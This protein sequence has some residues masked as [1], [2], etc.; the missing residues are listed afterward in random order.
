MMVMMVVMVASYECSM[1]YAMSAYCC[2]HDCILLQIIE[3]V[4]MCD[5]V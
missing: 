2:T 4:T 1:L 3:C 5:N